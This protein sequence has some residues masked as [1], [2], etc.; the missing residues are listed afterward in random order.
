[1]KMTPSAPSCWENTALG[2]LW[3]GFS[4]PDRGTLLAAVEVI[5]CLAWVCAVSLFVLELGTWNME[6]GTCNMGHGTWTM[7]HGTW[8]LGDLGV[9]VGRDLRGLL[10]SELATGP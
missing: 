5:P 3:V 1:M 7:E 10:R 9:Y 8:H 6:H 4:P 2:S